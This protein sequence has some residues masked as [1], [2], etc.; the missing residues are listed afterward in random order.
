[1]KN[2]L[3]RLSVFILTL[4]LGEKSSKDPL[5]Y[6]HARNLSAS[7][8]E[9]SYDSDAQSETSTR[10]ETIPSK[11]GADRRR[12][13][14]MQMPSLR[15]RRGHKSD[16]SGLALVAPPDAAPTNYAQLTPPPTANILSD[17]RNTPIPDTDILT[18]K[19]THDDDQNSSRSRRTPRSWSPSPS[20]G[21]TI[22]HVPLT[23]SPMFSPVTPDI[24]HG[25][26]IDIPV[27]GPIVVK[28]DSHLRK[29]PS[30]RTNSPPL[31]TSLLRTPTSSTVSSYLHYQPGILFFKS[32]AIITSTQAITGVHSLAGPL[33]PPPRA[34]F[35]INIHSPPPPRPPRFSSPTPTRSKRDLDAVKQSLQ[36]PPSVTAI[37]ASKSSNVSKKSSKECPINDLSDVGSKSDIKYVLCD[38]YLGCYEDSH[39]SRPSSTKS[40]LSDVDSKSDIKYVL[41]DIY[42]FIA[43]RLIY[44]RPPSERRKEGASSP[45]DDIPTEPASSEIAP[46]SATPKS[47]ESSNIENKDTTFDKTDIPSVTVVEPPSHRAPAEIDHHKFSQWLKSNPDVTQPLKTRRRGSSV[48]ETHFCKPKLSES[49]ERSD[50][51]AGSDAPSPPP[52]SLRNSLTI[53]MKRLS[54][55]RTASL[56]SRSARRWSGG[57]TYYS[58]RTPSPSIHRVSPS[59]QIPKITSTNPAA[60]FCHEVHSQRTTSERCLIYATK[61]NEL[62]LYDCGL[63]EWVVNM[64]SRGLFPISHS[65]LFFLLI[66]TDSRAKLTISKTTTICTAVRVSATTHFTI[67]SNIRSF[68]P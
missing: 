49:P 34:N 33:P 68:I 15:S 59:P 35:N 24:G 10:R 41:H 38:I 32:T 26:H 53:N 45:V 31:D 2:P 63:S 18:A 30:S 8:S 57:N 42:T 17:N 65:V 58:S 67:I 61:I 13:A 1:M 66:L 20:R 44:S 22:S 28:L 4:F 43:V 47:R 36:L 46:R 55:S 62:Y 23:P 29:A 19:N 64:K 14:I 21:L 54:L 27:A 9:Y 11:G 50:S 12:V 5:S 51:G 56:S 3:G 48:D 39:F 7:S 60:L 37:L 52:K 6:E 16:L 25:K 40:D